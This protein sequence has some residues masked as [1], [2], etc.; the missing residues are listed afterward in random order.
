MCDN[1]LGVHTNTFESMIAEDESNIYHLFLLNNPNLLHPSFTE[2]YL[3]GIL[4]DNIYSIKLTIKC[5]K[6][7]LKCIKM[8][9]NCIKIIVKC[10]KITIFLHFM[11][12]EMY[13]INIFLQLIKHKMHQNYWISASFNTSN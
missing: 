9:L 1:V 13:E 3:Q 8:T 10:I 4:G 6:M 7:T 2:S 5:I 11:K 12:H